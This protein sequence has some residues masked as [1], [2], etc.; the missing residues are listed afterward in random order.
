V[1][2]S[3]E[4]LLS[5]VRIHRLERMYLSFSLWLLLISLTRG[6]VPPGLNQKIYHEVPDSHVE[7]PPITEQFKYDTN[8]GNEIHNEDHHDHKSNDNVEE[9]VLDNEHII[10]DFGEILNEDEIKKMDIDE[11]LFLWFKAHDWDEND[12]MDGLELLKALSHDHNYHHEAEEEE[13][14][15][16]EI[17]DGVDQDQHT[18]AA[19]RQ[20][21]RRT[22]KIVDKILED[23]DAD[24]DGVISFPEFLIAFKSDNM[25]GL[26]V[27]KS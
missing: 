26:K 15:E 3:T 24:Y 5:N 14:D 18:P 27:K 19:N 13:G 12:Y 25:K 17:I 4:N 2:N 9:M 10:D 1:L 21:L 6:W 22:E 11:Q 8:V 23:N 20:R 7:A 16:H